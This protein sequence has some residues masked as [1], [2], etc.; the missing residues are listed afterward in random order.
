[1]KFEDIL[2]N[3]LQEQV[4]QNGDEEDD[5]LQWMDQPDDED[6]D[7]DPEQDVPQNIP[8][9][10]DVPENN[11]REDEDEIDPE[12]TP[13]VNAN[14]TQN[15]Q[16]PIS[17]IALLK[18]KWKEENPALTEENMNDVI[19]VFNRRKNGFRPFV[20]PNVDP[21]YV[22]QPEFVALH[23]VFPAFNVS[24]ITIIKDIT[25]Y[26]W[27]VMEFFMDRV[28]H[29]QIIGDLD[30]DIGNPN[31]TPI[32]DL[33]RNA[34]EKWNRS[35]NRVI[36]EGGLTVFKIDGKD[37]S[38]AL[39]RL[40]HLLVAKYNAQGYGN[41]WCITVPPGSGST[42]LFE[43]YRDRRSFYFVLDRNKPQDDNFY[44]S[45]ISVIDLTKNR[46]EGP[47]VITPRRN[48][49]ITR[50]SW[51]DLVRVYPQ[52]NGHEGVFR[53]IPK[54]RK[55]TEDIRL[56]Q[57]V[58][59]EGD[60]NDFAVQ[61]LLIQRRYIESGRL[62]N[63]PRAFRVLPFSDENNLR[64]EYVAR[65]TLNDYK[66]RFKCNIA[67]NPFGMLTLLQNE[68]PNIYHFLDNGV[69]RTQLN[70][71]N[72]ILD[73][74]KGIIGISYVEVYTDP[75]SKLVMYNDKQTQRMGIMNIETIEW[76]KP[77]DYK[78]STSM[79]VVGSDRKPLA[80]IRYVVSLANGDDYFYWLL[81][82]TAFNPKSVNKLE[83]K[84]LTKEQGDES[85]ASGAFKRLQ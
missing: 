32:D 33:F 42:N 78:R 60:P 24:D 57:I 3:L 63:S 16:K 40:Q 76:V 15:R 72:G 75:S 80:L 26:P 84:F 8:P 21:H 82:M 66:T 1:M 52:L 68:T 19:I 6:Q 77:I 74:K 58:F 48:G 28:N 38:I 29:A 61:N 44:V 73:L 53:I 79:L 20:D 71:R 34:Y 64:K 31:T 7:D 22:N 62:I 14:H 47:F 39:G 51:E 54:T 12:E 55:E 85:L 35:Y 25:K 4:N 18:R 69:L 56:D 2:L 13:Q 50:Q 43:S 23:E 27:N 65:T 83:G 81:P 46:N 36:N 49:D 17:P 67:A 11:E 45:V 70:I 5:E 59:R 9:V 30:Y 10:P 41:P 37:E